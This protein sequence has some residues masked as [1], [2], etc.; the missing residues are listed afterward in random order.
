MTDDSDSMDYK[1]K[2]DNFDYQHL[3]SQLANQ[4]EKNKIQF[5]KKR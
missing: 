5:Q 2:Q 1:E 3:I 4:T